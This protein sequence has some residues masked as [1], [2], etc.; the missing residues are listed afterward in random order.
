MLLALIGGRW[1][2]LADGDGRRRL[3]EAGDFVRLE[4][5]TALEHG[6]HVIPVLLDEA[7]MPK[8][9]ELPASMAALARRQALKLSDDRYDSDFDRLCSTIDVV[10]E[11][12][13][14]EKGE[15]AAA[16]DQD[17]GPASTSHGQV[18]PPRAPE[19][20]V[21]DT[22][23]NFEQLHLRS[24]PPYAGSGSVTKAMAG[25][26]PSMCTQ[27]STPSRPNRWNLSRLPRS[28]AGWP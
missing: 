7:V 15:T 11:R 2:T 26:P 22:R 21:P 16:P 10:L 6:K 14:Q 27:G 1:L 4:I 23:F 17:T 20:A 28:G 18:P 24:Q 12:D 19:L 25:P 13:R 9:D 3:D 5:E 8:P